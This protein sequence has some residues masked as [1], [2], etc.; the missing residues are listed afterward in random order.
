MSGYQP[1]QIPQFPF[2]RKDLM[3][4]KLF[5]LG[6]FF[7]N[8]LDLFT[9]VGNFLIQAEHRLPIVDH[10]G[11]PQS[12]KFLFRSQSLFADPLYAWLFHR[13]L[14]VSFPD[15]PSPASL[16][17]PLLSWRGQVPQPHPVW[18]SSLLPFPGPRRLLSRFRRRGIAN[19]LDLVSV[20]PGNRLVPVR[21]VGYSVLIVYLYIS[22]LACGNHPQKRKK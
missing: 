7:L 13:I 10:P 4:G 22:G 6:H 16:F 18:F 12:L 14:F 19:G 21:E 17:P 8:I 9:Q 1:R 3:E 20:L 2:V 11:C 5:H 15:P